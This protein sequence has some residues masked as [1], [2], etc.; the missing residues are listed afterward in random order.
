[1]TTV[2]STNGVWHIAFECEGR[3]TL[4]HQRGEVR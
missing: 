1:L 3:L 2:T 4:A